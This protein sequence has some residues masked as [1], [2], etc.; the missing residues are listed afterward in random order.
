MWKLTVPKYED[1]NE[2]LVQVYIF[3][4]MKKFA[5]MLHECVIASIRENRAAKIVVVRSL[6]VKS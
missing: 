2:C 3:T 1:K 5:V 6:N 4:H